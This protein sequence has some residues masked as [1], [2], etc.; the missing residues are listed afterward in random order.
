MK[1]SLLLFFFFILHLQAH[2]L[3]ENYLHLNF[4]ENTQTALITLEIETRL[5]ENNSSID[6]N[7][8]GIVSFKELRAHKSYIL[9]YITQHFHLLFEEEQLSLTNSK[10]FFHRYQDQTYLQITKKFYD[11][12]LDKL[13]LN[14]DM[15]FKQEKTHKL[16]IHLDDNRGDFIVNSTNRGYSFS[17][18]QMTQFK[19]VKIFIENGI[20]HILDGVD[21]LLF[22]LMILLPSIIILH[23]S[24]TINTVKFT[25]ISLLKIITT[26]SIAHSMTLF[27][28]GIGFFRP[29]ITFIESSI[30]LSIFVVASMN[31]MKQYNHVN[32][33]IVFLFGLLHGFGFANV[34]EMTKIDN[35][36]SLLVALFGFNFGVEIGQIFV[37][38]LLLP[39]LYLI[40]RVKLAV[41][42]L[43]SI[44]FA[45]M[46]ISAYWFFQRVGLM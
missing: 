27:I 45:A 2:Q 36:L 7:K 8:N 39:L 23:H 44:A 11:I 12:D 34:L 18:F 4:D 26:F 17:S 6:D 10:A 13:V 43:R 19:R 35:T 5:L 1:F 46:L 31:F 32:K 40:S 30:A 22:V 28:S 21:H 20:E 41:P 29:N 24:N 37:I 9:S 16:L 33:K 42:I 15:F 25:L 38:L 14:Y 3:K